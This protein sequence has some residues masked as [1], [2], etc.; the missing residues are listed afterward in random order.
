MVNHTS[1]VG[2]QFGAVAEAYLASTVHSQ[3][4]ELETIANRLQGRSEA[5]VLD[6]GCGAGHVSFAAAPHV[7]SVIAYDLS[8]E[9]TDT[10]AREA[11][12]RNLHNISTQ[13]GH[14]EELPFGDASFDW[15]CTRYSAHHWTEVRKALRETRRVLKPGGGLIIVDIFAPAN[16]L[17]DTHLQTI[18]LLR[19]GS[20]VRD[21][22]SIEWRSMIKGAGFE[23]GQQ[24]DWKVPLNFDAWVGRMKT[25]SVYVDAIRALLTN[26]PEEVRE[27]FQIEED[28]SFVCDA[29]LIEAN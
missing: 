12:R 3:G 5:R 17:L 1:K 24:H 4:A 20:H 23:V 16:P 27:Y 22:S 18:E 2:K 21:Y 11:E 29:A 26:A 13:T 6:L 15:V 10:V 14:A 28:G 9:M 7:G 19:D 8:A 25:P